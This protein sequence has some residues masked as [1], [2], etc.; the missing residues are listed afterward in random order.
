MFWEF[1]TLSLGTIQK[2]LPPL[3]I[4]P[5]RETLVEHPHNPYNAFKSREAALVPLLWWPDGPVKK[6]VSF[7]GGKSFYLK[8][9]RNMLLS[10]FPL[11]IV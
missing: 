11:L 3:P 7:C 4:A 5:V 6:K 1:T 8:L 10:G 9:R 2:I